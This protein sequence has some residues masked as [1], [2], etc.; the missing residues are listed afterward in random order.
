MNS[1][2]VNPEELMTTREI[3]QMARISPV[4]V[5]RYANAGRFGPPV[6]AP[7]PRSRRWSRPAV[8]R[9]FSPNQPNKPTN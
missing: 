5:R 3:A 4:A 8:L 7:G 6:Y 2:A 1:E 9:A